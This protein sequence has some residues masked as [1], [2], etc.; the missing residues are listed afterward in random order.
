MIISVS[1]D[2]LIY[3]LFS[4]RLEDSG[5]RV[6]RRRVGELTGGVSSAETDPCSSIDISSRK[7][8]KTT[9]ARLSDVPMAS[10]RIESP[11]P[12]AVSTKLKSSNPVTANG[13]VAPTKA[14]DLRSVLRKTSA[15][16]APAFIHRRS[17]VDATEAPSPLLKSAPVANIKPVE[18]DPERQ[19]LPSN[20]AAD[21]QYPTVPWRASGKVA[22][23]AAAN[24]MK[25]EDI[26]ARIEAL[27]A[28]ARQTVARV[29]RLTAAGDS[30]VKTADVVMEQNAPQPVSA[31]NPTPS[32]ADVMKA[33]TSGS[34]KA[35]SGVQ[36]LASRLNR[37]ATE[38]TTKTVINPFPSPVAPPRACRNKVTESSSGAPSPNLMKKN[39][40]GVAA[41][42]EADAAAPSRPKQQIENQC[43]ETPPPSSAAPMEPI[44]AVQGILKKKAEES[45]PRAK[46]PIDLPKQGV[47]I[48]RES[49][50]AEEGSTSSS[51]SDPSTCQSIL[52]RSYE[53]LRSRAESPSDP[54]SILKRKASREELES[55]RLHAIS[56]PHSILKRPPSRAESVESRSL[57]PEPHSILKRKASTTSGGLAEAPEASADPRPILKKRSST[58]ESADPRPI[59]KKKSS[60]DEEHDLGDK[61]KPILK[62]LKRF[63]DVKGHF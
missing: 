6:R 42:T 43:Q 5:K 61:P 27:T 52:H 51:T 14:S 7:S 1:A 56:E 55:D 13:N 46:S 41:K 4:L 21:A 22:I 24:T 63:V 60:T 59:L 44:K 40:S 31:P 11:A 3:F 2:P 10:S 47:R 28:M 62:S 37:T 29:D 34:D 50:P 8:A 33:G 49:Y 12:T 15:E 16:S 36:A 53:S 25:A 19:Q 39:V 54:I 45:E 30:T 32:N 26:T 18:S 57:S 48:R 20:P 17:A 58:D 38:A 23:P 35:S 9:A